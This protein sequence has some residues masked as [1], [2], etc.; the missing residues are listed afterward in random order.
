MRARPLRARFDYPL[1]RDDPHFASLREHPEM[2]SLMFELE[3][4]WNE[5]RSE[6]GHH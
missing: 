3:R 2:K 1:F 6:F 4:E 5:F